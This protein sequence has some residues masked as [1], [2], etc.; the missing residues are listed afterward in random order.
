MA[1]KGTPSSTVR[2]Y[3]LDPAG[4]ADPDDPK[5]I[6]GALLLSIHDQP[7]KAAK[8]WKRYAPD[9]GEGW[10]SITYKDKVLIPYDLWCDLHIFWDANI[11][12]VTQF[13]ES[14]HGSSFCT[15]L[16]SSDPVTIELSQDSQAAL[17]TILNAQTPVDPQILTSSVLHGALD[18]YN[19]RYDMVGGISSERIDQI[20]HLLTKL[21]P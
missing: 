3:V 14:G 17:Y 11:E 10:V 19:W 21:R 8:A 2:T 1:R 13:F 20:Q 12:V 15:T 4:A 5:S 16:F 18:F 6:P 7:R 9:P